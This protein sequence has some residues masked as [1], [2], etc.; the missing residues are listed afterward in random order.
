[1]AAAGIGREAEFQQLLTAGREAAERHGSVMFLAGRTGSGKSFLLKSFAAALADANVDVVSVVCYETSAANPLGP[2]VEALRALTNEERRGDRAKR[3]LELLGKVAPPLLELI[4]MVGTVAGKLAKAGTD[5]G[6]YALGGHEEQQKELAADVAIVLEHAADETPLVLVVDDAQWIDAASTEVIA[7]LTDTAAEHPLLLVVAYD[8]AL[9]DDAHPLAVARAKAVGRGHAVEVVLADLS[10]DGVAALLRSRYGETSGPRLAE[11]LHDRTDG[12]VLFLEQYLARLEEGGI[13]RLDG[14]AW[15]LDGTIEGKP[16]AWSLGGRLAGADTPGTMLELLRPRVAE[17]EDDERSLLETG[18]VQGRRFLSTVLV[19]LLDRDEDEVLDRLAQLAERRRMIEAQDV[20]DWWSDRSAQYTFDPGV[21]QELLYHRYAKSPYERRR[22]HRAVADALEELVAE[23]RPPPRHALLE[24]ARHYEQA[25]MPLRAA[26]K[27][28]EVADSTFAEGADRET[29][30]HAQRALALIESAA[31]ERLADAERADAK[32]LLAR[33]ILL[34]LLGGQSSW[35]ADSA[36]RE[37]ERLVELA[38][39][40]ECAADDLGDAK[41]KA[42]ARYAKALVLTANGGLDEALPVYQEALDLARAAED[43]LA[44]FAILVKY[45]HHLDSVDLHSGWELLQQAHELLLGALS[46]QLDE[47]HREQQRA[48]LESRL[49]IAAFDLGR[50]GEALDLLTRSSASLREFRAHG[51]GAWSLA[52]LAQAYTATGFYEA[53]EA[54]IREAIG[55]FADE[56]R[57]LGLRGYLSSLLG[58]LYLEWDVSKLDAARAAL[59]RGREET[60]AAGHRAVMPLAEILWAELLVAE[61]SP[62][63][64]READD[65]LAATTS[66]GWERSDISACSLRARIALL[67][68]RADEALELSLRAVTPLEKRRSVVPTIRAEEIFLSHARVLEGANQ[69]GAERYIDK[70]ARVV[71]QKADSLQDPA[72]RHSYLTRVRLS[73]EIAEAAGTA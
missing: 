34:L 56:P 58:H 46:D 57:A 44:E 39:E 11:W 70:A 19:R 73:R 51:E 48:L 22:R 10:A 18:A 1:M 38:G 62:E 4:P 68:G 53:G 37:K 35:I 14:D 72:Q 21:L 49:G 61:G 50:Y 17:L 2:F 47:R 9:A 63:S 69:E 16:G 36:S 8:P 52:F 15:R 30:V 40:A 32:R 5:V 23:D 54:T 25:G 59:L 3:V 60:K 65:V 33:A 55:I 26:A 29:G 13:L 31:P 64:L 42:N 28:V 71:R 7:R 43:P 24:I 6:V 12:N 20:E 66:F 67:Q 27:L 45:G 41:L